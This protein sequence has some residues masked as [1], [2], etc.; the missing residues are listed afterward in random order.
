VKL[1][2]RVYITENAAVGTARGD[3]PCCGTYQYSGTTLKQYTL[4]SKIHLNIVEKMAMDALT[5][6]CTIRQMFV[7][8]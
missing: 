5:F 7:K 4:L 1:V 2:E 3:K 8:Y 6:I